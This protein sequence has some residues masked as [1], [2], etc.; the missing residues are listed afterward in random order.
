MTLSGVRGAFVFEAFVAVSG[1]RWN[2]F[3]LWYV[4]A[5]PSNAD[6]LYINISM[7]RELGPECRFLRS[8]S[9][10]SLPLWQ[11]RRPVTRAT[12]RSSSGRGSLVLALQLLLF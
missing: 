4:F 1:L 9:A 11:S 5:L 10:K 7:Q 8:Q 2:M 6:D 3:S 12:S